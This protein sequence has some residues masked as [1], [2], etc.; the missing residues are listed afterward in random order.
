MVLVLAHRFEH[1]LHGEITRAEFLGDFVDLGRFSRKDRAAVNKHGG[2][3]QAHHRHHHPGQGLVASGET[4]QRIIAMPAHGQFHRVGD[5]F[6]AGQRRTHAFMA[7]RDTVR[8]GD[9]GEFARRA[10]GLL[11]THLHRLRLSVQRDVAR[12][13]FVP[14]GG[15]A[16]QRLVNLLLGHAHRVV[17]RPVRCAFRTFGDMPARKLGLVEL[18]LEHVPLPSKIPRPE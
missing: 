8:N 13:G 18:T 3:V 17:I 10:E 15:N 1:V 4:H 5:R 11:H 14:A 16:D 12:G 7:H 9:R 2:H 6:A